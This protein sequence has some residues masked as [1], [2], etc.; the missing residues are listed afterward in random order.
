[1]I[2]VVPH[3]VLSNAKAYITPNLHKYLDNFFNGFYA[4]L[5]DGRLQN[6]PVEFIRSDRGLVDLNN[7]LGLKSIFSGPAGGVAGGVV[8]YDLRS[9]DEKEKHPII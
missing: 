1:M 9:W 4:K 8:G 2:K 5:K 3:K 7:I 6:P